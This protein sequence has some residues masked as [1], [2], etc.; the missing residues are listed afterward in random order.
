MIR[1]FTDRDTE[2]LFREEKNR[3]F[4]TIAR[5]ICRRLLSAASY[6]RFSTHLSAPNLLDNPQ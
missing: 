5:S 3:R 1:N 4:N 6:R 2:Q